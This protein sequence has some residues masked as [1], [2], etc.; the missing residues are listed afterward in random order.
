M[1]PIEES[2]DKVKAKQERHEEGMGSAALEMV[3]KIKA[4]QPP[5]VSAAAVGGLLSSDASK[6]FAFGQ[7]QSDATEKK[8]KKIKREEGEVDGGEQKKKK[9]KTKE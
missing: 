6:Y 1:A 7:S 8:Q 3:K 4:A 2:G 9:K 5:Q